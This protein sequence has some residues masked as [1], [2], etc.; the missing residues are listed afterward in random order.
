MRGTNPHPFWSPSLSHVHSQSS[1]SSAHGYRARKLAPG[2]V[3][4]QRVHRGSAERLIRPELSFV[5]VVYPTAFLCMC[6][7]IPSVQV[8][9]GCS[10]VL[11]HVVAD[12]SSFLDVLL[13]GVFD[14][15][16]PL[17]V[18]LS[19]DCFVFLG[20][21]VVLPPVVFLWRPSSRLCGRMISWP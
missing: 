10:V 16:A 15:H 20:V 6:L 9:L 4:E 3:Q 5:D 18:S 7:G 13:V 11:G 21:L 17:S 12:V 1:V 19:G 14:M 2:L 8:D